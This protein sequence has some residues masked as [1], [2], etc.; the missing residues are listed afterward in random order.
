[1]ALTLLYV[2]YSLDGWWSRS[3]FPAD[4]NSVSPMRSG[5]GLFFVTTLDMYMY[6]HMCV[7]IYIY[8]YCVYIYIIYTYIHVY[9]YASLKL[10]DTKVYEP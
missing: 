9:I 8:I 1:M 6:T 10:S 2:P 7:Y 4:S 5:Q 3:V